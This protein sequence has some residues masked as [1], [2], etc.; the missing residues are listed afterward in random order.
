[1]Y[2]FTLF[3]QSTRFFT[4]FVCPL[5][6]SLPKNDAFFNKTTVYVFMPFVGYF[7]HLIEDRGAYWDLAI[8][9]RWQVFSVM[10][11]ITL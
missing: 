9:N 8:F 7:I 6:L 5:P 10:Q 2:I 3:R 1:M 11:R 4:H